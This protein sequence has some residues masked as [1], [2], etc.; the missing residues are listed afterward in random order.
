LANAAG[1]VVVGKIGTAVC[2]PEELLAAIENP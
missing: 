2:T 1:G